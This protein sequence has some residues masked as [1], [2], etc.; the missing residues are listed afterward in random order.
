MNAARRL[1]ILGATGSVG[2]AALAAAQAG[3]DTIEV[4]TGG[5][6]APAMKDICVKF[7][8]Q[9]AIMKN[10]RAAET[11]HSALAAEGIAAEI[12]VDGGDE[13]IRTAAGDCCTVVAGIAG[14]GGLPPILEAARCGKR[15]LL[16]NKESLVFAGELLMQTARENGA[17]ILPI[18]SEHAA[19]FFLLAA[20]R[21]YAKMW[22]T[23]SGG[24]LRDIPE[25]RLADATPAEVLA[26]PT[27][28]MGRKITVDSATM[29]N[30]SLEVIEASVLFSAKA[31]DIGVVLH[32]QSVVHAMLEEA[33]GTL[34]A[35]MA[36]PDMQKSVA[37]MLA[38]PHNSPLRA[39]APDWS[40]LSSL[41]FSPPS[42]S[43][44][45]CL[46]LAGA[47]LSAGGAAPAALSA[48]NET[49]VERF[50][51]GDIKFT[52]IARI[53]ARALEKCGAR[54]AATLADLRAADEESR[55][56]AAE[57]RQ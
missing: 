43:R 11:L 6:N 7:R 46:A 34:T 39:P 10:A 48:A 13:A 22:L 50:L 54:P 38:W 57:Y 41:S 40:T 3:G 9:R 24:A 44:Y 1:C 12:A 25:D 21:D 51:A 5:E 26:H 19:L 18:D 4:L 17:T 36:F 52:D 23:A 47:A 2:G 35:Q 31:D 45:P 49:A 37:R 42:L 16:A 8:P 27:W 28:K 15:I 33:D 55:A 14:A 56:C 30:K 29:M 20:R 53:N 32:P